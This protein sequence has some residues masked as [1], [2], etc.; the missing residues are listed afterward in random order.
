[1]ALASPEQ[2]QRI[3]PLRCWTDAQIE[4]LRAAAAHV[5]DEWRGAW[6]SDTEVVQVVALTWEHEVLPP[7]SPDA[8]QR[9]LQAALFGASG[10]AA[11]PGAGGP[12]SRRLRTQAWDDLRLRAL[13]WAGIDLVAST[14][15]SPMTP[16]AAW[17]GDVVL[18]W[19]W[20]NLEGLWA[21]PGTCVARLV[22]P[23][24]VSSPAPTPQVPLGDALSEHVLR[25]Q[26][27]LSPVSLR[28][29]DLAS[30]GVGD[31][32]RLNHA[33]DQPLSLS[34]PGAQEPLCAGWLGQRNGHKALE[35]TPAAGVLP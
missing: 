27:D 10:P 3:Q 6:S 21:V 4:A 7:A 9:A 2:E 12:L 33:L 5:L 19:R 17:S 29:G 32:V 35:L 26:A 28:L 31:I 16:P 20:R 23:S 1:M 8:V 22:P 30:L 14:N 25:V 24:V 11:A 15:Q 34:L 13:A 18:H